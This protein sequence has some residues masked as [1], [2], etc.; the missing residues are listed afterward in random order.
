MTAHTPPPP[1][2]PFAKG[3]RA[4]GVAVVP[5]APNPLAEP[6]P[7]EFGDFETFDDDARLER[8]HEKYFYEES[9]LP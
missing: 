8:E 4:I 5:G 3:V 9:Y 6:A 2:D 1:T 7:D